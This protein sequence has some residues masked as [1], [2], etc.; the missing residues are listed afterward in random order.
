MLLFNISNRL[1]LVSLSTKLS[2]LSKNISAHQH[3]QE[4]MNYHKNIQ[5]HW[6]G[7]FNLSFSDLLERK[8]VSQDQSSVRS[9]ERR[10]YVVI[11]F[12]AQGNAQFGHKSLR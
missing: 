7:G 6:K 10:F 11:T 2:Y 12:I 9:H 8:H 1:D 4:N 3:C 5:I